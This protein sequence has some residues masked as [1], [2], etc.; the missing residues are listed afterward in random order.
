[1]LS[2]DN[3]RVQQ[4]CDTHPIPKTVSYKAISFHSSTGRIPSQADLRSISTLV[5]PKVAGA[6]PAFNRV[7]NFIQTAKRPAH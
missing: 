3:F 1:M 4:C 2:L 7:C 5:W 6:Q